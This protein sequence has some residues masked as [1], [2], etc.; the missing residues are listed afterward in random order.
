MFILDVKGINGVEKLEQA[1]LRNDDINPLQPK[2]R[3][4]H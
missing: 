1:I 2:L 4:A 3:N